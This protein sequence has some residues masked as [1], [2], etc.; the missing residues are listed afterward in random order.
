MPRQLEL[1]GRS[2]L[3]VQPEANRSKPQLWIRR[4]VIWC[5]PGVVLREIRLRPGLNIIWAPDPADRAGV[6]KQEAVL[7][8]GS[9]K[10]CFVT[11]RTSRERLRLATAL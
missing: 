10:T 4:L 2:G 6:S 3:Q 1:L 11:N 7:G 5:E 9:G 8:H